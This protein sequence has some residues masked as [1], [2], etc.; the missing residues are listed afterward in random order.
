MGARGPGRGEMGESCRQR[1]WMVY[2]F[3]SEKNL[4]DFRKIRYG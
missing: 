2:G 3:S 1:E 4:V